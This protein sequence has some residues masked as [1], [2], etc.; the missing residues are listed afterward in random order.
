MKAFRVLRFANKPTLENAAFVADKLGIRNWVR[1]EKKRF[2]ILLLCT[3][4]MLWRL[5]RNMR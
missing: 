1:F 5:G 4:S 3:N 2:W